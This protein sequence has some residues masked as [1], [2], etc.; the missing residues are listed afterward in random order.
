MATTRVTSRA[1]PSVK[2]DSA[3]IS[4]E[5]ILVPCTRM[6]HLKNISDYLAIELR[7]EARDPVLPYG[8]V[9]QR[10]DPQTKGSNKWQSSA[11]T[12]FATNAALPAHTPDLGPSS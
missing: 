6:G 3:H 12:Q 10:L 7:V 8:A 4:G 9:F 11:N 2:P 1:A 5:N